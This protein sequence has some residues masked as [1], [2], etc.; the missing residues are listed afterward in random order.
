MRK[1][2][3][4]EMK[5]MKNLRLYENAKI[6]IE[7]IR[8]E[9]YS[10]MNYL[11]FYRKFAPWI[12]AYERKNTVHFD[13]YYDKYWNLKIP[14]EDELNHDLRYQIGRAYKFIIKL[15]ADIFWMKD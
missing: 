4:L 9:F 6:E 13:S 3:P 1:H 2:M 11:D 5:D 14:Q 15:Q 7:K 10:E 12:R 8:K